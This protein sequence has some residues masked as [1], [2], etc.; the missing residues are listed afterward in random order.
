MPPPVRLR[1]STKRGKPCATFTL[2]FVMHGMKAQWVVIRWSSSSPE[3]ASRTAPS[4]TEQIN[5]AP[6]CCLRYSI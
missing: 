3:A 1:S 5:F 2:N 4:H 6:L